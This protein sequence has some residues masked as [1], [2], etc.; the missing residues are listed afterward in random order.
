MN[1]EATNHEEFFPSPSGA[2]TAHDYLQILFRRR[3]TVL[4]IFLT[5]LGVAAYQTLTVTPIYT[6]KVQLL[7]ERQLPRVLGTSQPPQ[8]DAFNDEFY[9]T[10]YKLL[11]SLAL[12][13]KVADKLQLQNHP[14]FSGIFKN[15]P[16]D[17]DLA[18]RER[19]EENLVRAVRG[20]LTVSPVKNS[21]L[22]DL[23][24]SHTDPKFAAE[25][26]NAYAKCF[27][28]QSLDLRFA[29][30]QE[31]SNWLQ[32]KLTEARKKLEASEAKLNRY[33]KEQNIVAPGDKETIT[34]QKLEQLNKELVIAQTHRMEAET[35]YNQVI[36]GHDIPEVLNNPLI[37]TLKGAEAQIVA[38]LSE[39]GKKYGPKHPR[40]IR[41]NNELAATR[42]K[43]AAETNQ[44]I[45]SIKNEYAMAQNQEANLKKALQAVKGETQDFSDRAIQYRVL[46]RDV[47]TNRVLYENIL[48]SFKE[49]TTIENIPATNIRIVYPATIPTAPDSTHKSRN[50]LVGAGLGL[51][52]GFA[53]AMVL[54]TLDT[55]IKTPEEAE[56]RL[57]VPS[58]GLIPHMQVAAD[59]TSDGYPVLFSSSGSQPLAAEAYRSLRTS[60]LFSTPGHPPK[61]LLVTSS[62]P[63]EG[64]SLTAVNVA[65]VMAKAEGNIL[66]VDSDLRRP[67]LHKLFQLPPEPGLTNFL[68]GEIDEVPAV[69]TKMPHL[70]VV[71]C[72]HIPPNPS[73][74]LGSE[75][76]K[77]FLDKA[78]GQYA[79][80][81][82]DSPPL[83]S[84]TDS[85]IL[86]T[87]VE[88]VLLVIKAESIPR[89]AATEARDQLF[90]VRAQLLGTLLNDVSLKRDG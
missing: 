57:G 47:E 9:Q 55:T 35:R 27:I 11:E 83:L 28:E 50:L 72:G 26:A 5:I 56:T 75:S 6:A 43:I 19:A 77:A 89:K 25:L 14:Y 71:P 80:V 69:P 86:A 41:L 88:G 10:Q 46:L 2:W 30:S 64:K 54:E 87:M 3:W 67:S 32:K 1:Q 16:R 21:R 76:M 4:M 61:T 38:Q 85:T 48:K 40:M 37:Q 7:I 39:L 33:K 59:S 58:L 44:V 84:V 23:N 79:R 82:I 49:T 20:G 60:I 63:L 15:L 62:L 12:A 22:V 78:Q 36:Q 45:Q 65:T 24:Y 34:T 68:V 70:F 74:L 51:F 73:E 81:I 53:L 66:L 42:S 18:L 31:T 8:F 52:F 17:A 29:A 90:G 13:K